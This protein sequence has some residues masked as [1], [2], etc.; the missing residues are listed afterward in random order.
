M[1][2]KKPASTKPA[3][4]K[5]AAKAT[6]TH[7]TWI[8]MIKVRITGSTTTH[9]AFIPSFH[10]PAHGVSC[11]SPFSLSLPNK[12]GHRARRSPQRLVT[13]IMTTLFFGLFSNLPFY[14]LVLFQRANG[15]CEHPICSSNRSVL[16]L[17]L[18]MLAKVSP[19]PKSRSKSSQYRFRSLL[20]ANTPR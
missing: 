5:A 15:C 19:A 14:T 16:L 18:T 13:R 11:C 4:K 17:T 9:I 20:N 7:P 10:S 12:V 6:P 2:A 8:E 1:S 3:S